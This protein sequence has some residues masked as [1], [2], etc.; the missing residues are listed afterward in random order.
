MAEYKFSENSLLF[1][2]NNLFYKIHG[3][4]ILQVLIAHEFLTI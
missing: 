2:G 4:L 1:P 3:S